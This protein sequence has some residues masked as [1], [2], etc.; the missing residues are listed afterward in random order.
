MAGSNAWRSGS[1]FLTLDGAGGG[2]IF[3]PTF[4]VS[5]GPAIRT[6]GSFRAGDLETGW[7]HFAVVTTLTPPKSATNGNGTTTCYVD[8]DLMDVVPFRING[9]LKAIGDRATTLGKVAEVRVWSSALTTEEMQSSYINGVSGREPELAATSAERLAVN[10]IPNKPGNETVSLDHVDKVA[11]VLPFPPARGRLRDAL[12]ILPTSAAATEYVTFA[13]PGN[14]QTLPGCAARCGS[15]NKREDP[16]FRAGPGGG[17]GTGVD[18]Q[19]TVRAHPARLHRGAAPIPSENLTI[20]PESYNGATALTLSQSEEVEFTWT[21]SKNTTFGTNLDFFLGLDVEIEEGAA[22]IAFIGM[23]AL[24]FKVGATGS[25]ALSR[26]DTAENTVSTTVTI[27]STDTLAL[28][29]HVE[30]KP[31]FPKLGPR[32]LPKNVG[33][34]LVVSALGDVFI[35]RLKRSRR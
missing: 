24:K 35:T 17:V 7:H 31:R 28:R 1:P 25:F 26:S 18:R 3:L 5:D 12:S 34:A 23:K 19:R 15:G 14:G 4:G 30:S 6:P 16:T 10:V 22:A 2:S 29:G 9:R 27:S 20:N 32:F 13:E 21:Q 8:G 33:Y 11:D